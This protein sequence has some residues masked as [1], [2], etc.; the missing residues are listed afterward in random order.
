MKIHIC[1]DI[2]IRICIM[3]SMINIII[4]S[5]LE[6]GLSQ[7]QISKMA[8]VPQS[9]ISDISNGKQATIS[10]EAGKRLEALEIEIKKA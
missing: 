10:Y 4:K 6:A 5:L 3:L 2:T 7:T 9:R 1:I 8:N